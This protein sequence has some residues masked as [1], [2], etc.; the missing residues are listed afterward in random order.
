[1]KTIKHAFVKIRVSVIFLCGL[2]LLTNLMCKKDTDDI[3]IDTAN[4]TDSNKTKFKKQGEVSFQ[5]SLKNFVK[6]IDVEIADTDDARHLGLMF[7]EGMTGDQGMLFIFPNEE[8][9][10]FYMKN[11]VMPLDII[12]I[13]AKKQIVKIHKNTQPLSEK[14]LPSVKPA[15]YVVEVI[16]GFTDKYKIKEGDYIDW[17]RI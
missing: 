3:K 8:V 16:S 11:T 9:Q 10:G 2:L 15:L 12:F 5:D 14:T 1:M 4:Q 7:R 13:N 6:K 17:R